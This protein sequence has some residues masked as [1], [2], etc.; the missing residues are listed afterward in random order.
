MEASD[1]SVSPGWNFDR[2]SRPRESSTFTPT[3]SLYAHGDRTTPSLDLARQP[4][5]PTENR[6]DNGQ[7]ASSTHSPFSANTL[8]HPHRSEQ[9]F[10]QSEEMPATAPRRFA[11]DG[12]DYRRPV[13]SA[14]RQRDA[15]SVDLTAEEEDLAIDLSGEDEVIDLTADD[16]GYGASQDDPAAAQRRQPP[17]PR[18]LPRGMDIIIDLD[19]GQEE[20]RLAAPVAEP[21]SPEIQFI[22]SRTIYQPRQTSNPP[23]TGADM[24]DVEFVEVRQLPEEEQA[25]RRRQQD[26]DNMVDLL[27]TMNGQFHHLQD[28]VARFAANINRTAANMNMH[29]AAGRSR[30]APVPPPRAPPRHG[31]MRI[32]TFVT[33]LMDFDLVGFEMG[34]FMEPEP[35]EPTTYEAPEKAPEGFTRTVDEKD[36]LVCPNCGDELCAG[37]DELKSQVWIVKSCGHV[38]V[39]L[40]QASIMLLFTDVLSRS[41][42]V[43]VQPIAPLNAVQRARR[44]RNLPLPRLSKLA[45]LKVAGKVWC[46]KRRCSK[47]FCEIYRNAL[48]S[49]R[50]GEW[51]FVSR[52]SSRNHVRFALCLAASI[53]TIPSYLA[54]YHFCVFSSPS[55]RAYFQSLRV[56]IRT[57]MIYSRFVHLTVLIMGWRQMVLGLVRIRSRSGSCT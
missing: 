33:P 41:T 54:L 18:R 5:P 51:L 48:D 11:G 52:Q 22:S 21:G 37:D 36:V 16:S 40:Y 24:D 29:R 20:W 46:I 32:G 30:R 15:A 56:D 14:G 42:A 44:K 39:L 49:V 43:N 8:P 1:R 38:C 6:L 7:A 55:L 45:L 27:G 4:P 3:G 23:P 35:A 19:N 47:S 12:F 2:I 34:G 25:R 31:H 28:H 53:P 50:C 57:S 9:H 13:S 17:P 26:I 10:S